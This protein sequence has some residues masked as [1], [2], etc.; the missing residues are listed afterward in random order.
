MDFS[1]RVGV[2][3][4][5]LFTNFFFS[6]FPQMGDLVM[7]RM[8]K[9]QTWGRWDNMHHSLEGFFQ[10]ILLRSELAWEVSPPGLSPVIWRTMNTRSF[11]GSTG[12]IMQPVSLQ[13][14]RGEQDSRLLPCTPLPSPSALCRL[15]G[16]RSPAAAKG[17]QL[18]FC[19]CLA[20]DIAPWLW[21]TSSSHRTKR[22]A[23]L[24][25]LLGEQLM[26]TDVCLLFGFS[27]QERI[28]GLGK[29]L[30]V[31]ACFCERSISSSY[32]C[33]PVLLTYSLVPFLTPS[34]P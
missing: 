26:A 6:F 5:L 8:D 15:S 22:L 20:V 17:P 3:Y 31:R 13:G 29:H 21:W 16:T 28:I 11:T 25:V 32:C 14:S 19:Y 27:E 1:T 10:G 9:N 2:R 23:V 12:I 34:C 7:N 30:V 33:T 24:T 18:W 4:S